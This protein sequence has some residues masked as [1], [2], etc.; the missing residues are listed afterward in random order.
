M[1]LPLQDLPP[2]TMRLRLST[3]LEVYWDRIAV[4]RA[5]PVTPTH[6]S[7]APA[8]AQ[9]RL[10]GFPSRSTADQRLPGYDYASREP[11][12]DTR[13]PRGI[14]SAFGSVTELVARTDDAVAIIGPGEEVEFGFAIPG[15]VEPGLKRHYVLEIRGWAK[16]MDLYT[17]DGGT[18]DP[19]PLR[20]VKLPGSDV[21]DDL[22]RRYH[23][24]YQSGR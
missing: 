3:N 9:Q 16:D 13:Y 20:D 4:A 18:V 14:Y 23:T 15:Q 19:L 12:W 21:R 24:R 10:T 11:F 6:L 17:R 5:V 22:H 7:T 8:Y 1:A 2:G